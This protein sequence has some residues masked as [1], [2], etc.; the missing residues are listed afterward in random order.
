[1][2]NYPNQVRQFNRGSIYKQTRR[3]TVSPVMFQNMGNMELGNSKP[4]LHK[5]SSRCRQGQHFGRQTEQVQG[6]THRMD[7][8]QGHCTSDFSEVGLP[9]GRSVCV[10]SEQTNTSLLF[11]DSRSECPGNRCS[12]NFLGRHVCLGVPSDMPDS[13]SNSTHAQVS[14]SDHSDSSPVAQETLVYRNPESTDS[15]SN[16]TTS[17]SGSASATQISDKTS[18]SRNIQFDSLVTFN[19]QFEKRGFSQETKKLLCAS[20]RTG[21]Q[22]DYVSKF[23]KFSSWCDSREIDPYNATLT[24]IA[25]FLT[26]LYTSGLQYRTIA[27]YRSML[28]SILD[29]V[30][31]R[32]VGQHPY[33]VRLLKGIFNSRPPK[34]KL[35]P[36]WEL[37]KVLKMLEKGPFEPMGKASLKHITLKTVFLVAITTFRRCSDLQ[38]LRIGEEAVSVQ[39][40]G[41]TFIRQGLSKQDRP[42]HYGS[43][44][45]VPAFT[46]N[47]HLDPKRALYFYL[48]ITDSFRQDDSGRDETKLFLS[49]KKPH[50]PVSSQTISRWIVKT[51]KMAYKFDVAGVKGHSTRA[52]GPSWAL[53]N[54]ASIKSILE[55]ADWSRETTFIRFYLR[56]VDMHVLD[57]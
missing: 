54:G 22:K 16:Q 34:S 28:S 36:E 57:K 45:F 4:N 3:N 17:N 29:S 20:W 44:I 47:K 50:K 52:V 31:N 25:D 46:S 12:D 32:P 37:P 14:L 11:M 5:S 18:E 13:Q 38:S 26:H 9:N 27:G 30:E 1:M 48:K 7:L 51:V 8:E 10:P 23:K 49:I 40:K 6:N 42:S 41:V 53:Y 19:K 21:T 15:L 56:D 35:L 39:K 2:S 33:I 55:A 43:K 24:Q